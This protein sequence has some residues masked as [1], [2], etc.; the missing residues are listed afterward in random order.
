MQLSLCI[1][2][3]SFPDAN[4]D[5]DDRAID[6][7]C[8]WTASQISAVCSLACSFYLASVIA[9]AH[10]VPCTPLS[11]AQVLADFACCYSDI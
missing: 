7:S 1:P 9:H 5:I 8:L 10:P 3:C 11:T 4:M 2:P 6:R